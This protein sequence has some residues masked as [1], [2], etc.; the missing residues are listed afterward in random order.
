M[1]SHI[2]RKN[3]ESIFSKPP[4]MRFSISGKPKIST[5]EFR[6][7]LRHDRCES[8]ICLRRLIILILS[9]WKMSPRASIWSPISSN[10]TCLLSTICS[11]AP[12]PTP[13]SS[14]LVIL[15]H[16]FSSRGKKSMTVQPIFDQNTIP[17]N[18][19]NFSNISGRLSNIGPVRFL[20]SIKKNSVATTISSFAKVDVPSLSCRFQ[21]TI[22]SLSPFS[23][24][25]PNLLK[26]R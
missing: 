9:W 17:K 15:F 8:R 19:K 11:K 12:M 16:K 24:V 22:N 1:I 21:T 6:S 7:I 13:I 10:S 4:K 3:L 23:K 25:I 18:S 26:K 20:S 14:S 5:R 2:F